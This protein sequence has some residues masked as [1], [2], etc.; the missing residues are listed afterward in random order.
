MVSDVSSG[1]AAC[2]VSVP[3]YGNNENDNSCLHNTNDDGDGNVKKWNR[4]GRENVN[5]H[6][7]CG[8]A[9]GHDYHQHHNP[10]ASP[11][12]ILSFASAIVDIMLG[13]ISPLLVQQR[14]HQSQYHHHSNSIGLRDQQFIRKRAGIK[15]TI[16]SAAESIIFVHAEK[17]HTFDEHSDLG[18]FFDAYE[19]CGRSSSQVES[20][21]FDATSSTRSLSTT[22]SFVS[23]DNADEDNSKDEER[24]HDCC[25]H[26]GEVELFDADRNIPQHIV[27]AQTNESTATT[28]T[29]TTP[30]FYLDLSDVLSEKEQDVITSN[31]NEFLICNENSTFYIVNDSIE[32][33][34]S[35]HRVLDI[36]VE[37][38]FCIAQMDDE[39]SSQSSAR[40]D[41][42]NHGELCWNPDDRTKNYLERRLQNSI[43]AEEWTHILETE[44]LKWIGSARNFSPPM[45]KTRGIIDMSPLELKDLLLDCERNHLYN[46]NSI[47]KTNMHCFT[48]MD[49][50]GG[51]TKI[52]QNVMKIPLVGKAIQ[53]VSLTHVRCVENGGYI[54][55]S[56]S[57][58]D[59]ANTNPANPFFSISILRSVPNC[60]QKTELTNITRISSMP[61]PEFLVQKVGLM[62]AMDFF[63][64]LRS[65][66]K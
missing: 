47:S 54:L 60:E 38:S 24:D 43:A 15:G 10:D 13:A 50:I 21:Y 37:R 31:Y 57:V 11:F 27:L 34:E 30:T 17:M 41:V 1:A 5:Y 22:D 58:G 64:N 52:V 18:Q 29:I 7:T 62:G 36:L 49:A 6:D 56:Q 61:M 39:S 12:G 23:S 65:L 33:R 20:V 9:H 42:A 26:S 8:T 48:D 66:C 46:Q 45:L 28:P 53:T 40:D 35:F 25:G 51:E 55:V 44:V 14:H 63:K 4:L 19:S 3:T 32:Y 2:L 16:S 59:D